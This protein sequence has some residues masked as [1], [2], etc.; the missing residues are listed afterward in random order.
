[1]EPAELAVTESEAEV[2]GPEG[3]GC[4]LLFE[5]P[6]PGEPEEEDTDDEPQPGRRDDAARA[7]APFMACRR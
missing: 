7:S 1:M 4:G 3:V 6:P 5:E 2:R